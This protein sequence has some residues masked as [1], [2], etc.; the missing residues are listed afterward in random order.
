METANRL[1]KL[2]TALDRRSPRRLKRADLRDFPALYRRLVSEL[3]EARARN[4]PVERLA[5]LEALVVRAHALLY[6]P[7]P[8]RLGSAVRQ[9]VVSFPAAVRQS[10]RYVALA[11]ALLFGGVIWGY[12]EVGR[13]PSNAA[14]FLPG[15]LQENAEES[16]QEGGT[17]REG[18][19]IYGVFYFVNNARVAFNAFA[20]GATFGV[21]TVLILLFNGI[22][23]GATFA[24]VG[25]FG[26]AR[27][28]WSFVSPHAGV[29]MAA[30]VIA[31]A[32]GLRIGDSLLRPGWQRRRDAFARGAREALPLALGSSLL[33]L[34]AGFVE[35]WISP[36]PFPLATKVM[37]GGLLDALLIVFLCVPISKNASGGSNSVKPLSR[38]P[39]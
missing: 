29:E 31:A 32:G 27:V 14:V 9:L 6:A 19:P 22:I 21:G 16:F 17:P 15:Q 10:S 1:T 38:A 25:M 2:L 23:L 3:A 26:S 8:V 37:I 35:G 11:V 24:L 4:M 18:D 36:V 20:L 34:V 33:L 28:F 13:D 5:E 7:R 30:I 39:G 12:L